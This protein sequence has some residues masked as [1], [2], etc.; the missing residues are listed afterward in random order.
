MPPPQ[1][2][3]ETNVYEPKKVKNKQ[4]TQGDKSTWKI[5][6]Q[7]ERQT[8]DEYKAHHDYL[9]ASFFLITAVKERNLNKAQSTRD[10]ASKI[11]ISNNASDHLLAP[12]DLEWMCS[13]I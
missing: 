5:Q 12:L 8:V 2:Y 10:V 13:F 1:D 3:Q 9:L 7:L 11:L 4:I 6:D